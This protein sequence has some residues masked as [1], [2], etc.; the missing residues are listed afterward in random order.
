MPGKTHPLLLSDTEGGKWSQIRAAGT[1][2]RQATIF[3]FFS[4]KPTYICVAARS[5][6][7]F[8]LKNPGCSGSPMLVFCVADLPKSRSKRANA[9]DVTPID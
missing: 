1:P 7:A 6:D 9:I 4:L 5:R 2:R 8:P 3:S